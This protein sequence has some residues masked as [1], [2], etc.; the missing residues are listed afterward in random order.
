MLGLLRS[1]HRLHIQLALQTD[2]SE[3]IFFPRK[4]RHRVQG[5]LF[6]PNEVTN[7]KIDEAVKKEQKKRFKCLAW[8]NFS[9]N[10]NC[11]TPDRCNEND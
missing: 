5:S 1:L 8:L 9:R 11:G 6:N 3:E 7:A 2:S 4:A 10:M